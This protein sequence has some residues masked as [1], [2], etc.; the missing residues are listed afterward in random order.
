MKYL[1][2]IK[3]CSHCDLREKC[4]YKNSP[5]NLSPKLRILKDSRGTWET[6]CMDFTREDRT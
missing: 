5:V 6:Y 1:Y 3:G 2:S 4:I